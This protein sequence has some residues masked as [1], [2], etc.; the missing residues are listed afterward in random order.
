MAYPP[1]P[2]EVRGTE[3]ALPLALASRK[4]RFVVTAEVELLVEADDED[5]AAQDAITTLDQEAMIVCG[6]VLD[7]RKEDA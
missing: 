4:P 1:D 3:V 7:V 6:I 5:E 2:V